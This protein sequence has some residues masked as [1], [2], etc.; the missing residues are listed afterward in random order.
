MAQARC[1]AQALSPSVLLFLLSSSRAVQKMDATAP[2][3]A[4]PATLSPEQAKTIF[5]TAYEKFSDA[6]TKK[7]LKGIV[8]EANKVEDPMM[9]QMKMMQDLMPAV[10]KLMNDEIKAYGFTDE[11]VLMGVMQ[12]QLIAMADP[13]LK[14]KAQELAD[15]LQGKFKEG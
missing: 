5:N 7:E 8:E 15:A 1:A 13:E 12:V 9:R 10:Q 6:E 14:D 2:P 3:M 11:T 4:P